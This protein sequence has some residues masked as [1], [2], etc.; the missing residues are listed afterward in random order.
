MKSFRDL[1]RYVRDRFPYLRRPILKLWNTYDNI[2]F[3]LYVFKNT[4]PFQN[5]RAT[6]DPYQI[7]IIES[8]VIKYNG[9]FDFIQDAGRIYSG[10]WDID[11]NI[12]NKTLVYRSF[13]QH[14]DKGLPWKETERYN[15]H[16]QKVKKQDFDRCKTIDALDKW[17]SRYDKLF[18]SI[19]DDGYKTQEEI[20]LHGDDPTNTSGI[21]GI[22]QKSSKSVVVHEIAV[23][24]GR[25]GNFHLDDGRHRLSMAK[26]LG[27]EVPI[28]VVVRHRKWQD[29]RNSVAKAADEALDEGIPAEDVETYI[30]DE[31]S[32]ELNSV[33]MGF[34]HPDIQ[35]ILERRLGVTNDKVSS[36]NSA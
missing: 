31:L 18:K 25:N 36:N 6:I 1:I 12:F 8:H 21:G 35:V 5:E 15:K 10:M 13:E 2:K 14:F 32:N 17:Y 4:Y 20:L 30:K 26:L 34:N 19:S 22:L 9:V 11:T 3:N 24:I 23:S 28:R 27:I 33:F 7:F 29:L 16:A